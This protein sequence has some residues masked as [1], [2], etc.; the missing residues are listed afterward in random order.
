MTGAVRHASRASLYRS[1][2]AILSTPGKPPVVLTIAGF[3]PTSGAGVTADLQVFASL[4][5]FGTA[6]LTAL[7]VQSTKGVA[8]VKPVDADLLREMFSYLTED[9]IP[10]GIKIG[11]LGNAAVTQVVGDFLEALSSHTTVPVVIDPVLRSSS[12]T[13]LLDEDAIAILH[14]RVF[15]Y[16]TC[17]TPNQAELAA[18]SGR[19]SLQEG[20]LAD[21]ALHLLQRTG[22]TSVIVTGGDGDPP[23]DLLVLAGGTS[24]KLEG[25]RVVTSST[26]G[27]GCAFS[28]AL[29]GRLVLG[30][31]LSDAAKAAKRFVEESLRQAPGLGTGK[32]P[33]KLSTPPFAQENKRT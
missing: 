7:T 9:L 19:E 13:S 17:I 15:P 3:D 30:D 29:L 31:D 2:M 6:C 4:G 12:G 24:L 21:A 1:L 14:E 33:M 11:M 26:H 23:T 8:R 27:T 20:E 5:L 18:L 25:S 32:G 28:S 22:A 16:A 10:S